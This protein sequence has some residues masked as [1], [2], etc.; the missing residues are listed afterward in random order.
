MTSHRQP[1]DPLDQPP[2]QPSLSQEENDL[3]A[4]FTQTQVIPH[5]TRVGQQAALR[6]RRRRRWAYAGFGVALLLSV[7]IWLIAQEQHNSNLIKSKHTAEA[8]ASGNGALATKGVDLAGQINTACR[9]GAGR[10]QMASLGI[11]CQQAS[12]LAT[13]APVEV[14][15]PAGAPGVQGPSGPPGPTGPA[16]P[17]GAQGS[18]G[19]PGANG[20]PGAS[21]QPGT[22]VNGAN[23]NDGAQGS[24]GPA[25]PQG[26]AGPAGPAG[27][28]GPAGEQGPQGPAGATG[29]A[30]PDCPAGYTP[31]PQPQLDGGSV[32]VCSSPPAPTPT[33]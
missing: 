8:A 20:E 26:S 13:A 9:T 15:G 2:I 24:P 31:T 32:I 33:P 7:L 6:S 4:E 11:S 30:G 12:Q 14:T 28:Q 1:P 17:A 16:G 27:A 5:A 22:G 19:H 25:G 3:L 23:G 10:A 18:P 29:P 21:G